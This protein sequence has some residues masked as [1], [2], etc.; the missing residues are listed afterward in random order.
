MMELLTRLYLWWKREEGQGMVEYALI[1]AAIAVVVI[2]TLYALGGEI[3][4][5]FQT[6]KQ[7]VAGGGSS[8][9]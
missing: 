7:K 2:V 1:L 8:T 6:I 4:T 9:P 3:D 5:L